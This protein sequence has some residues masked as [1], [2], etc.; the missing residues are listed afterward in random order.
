MLEQK[1]TD[2][3]IDV[4][5]AGAGMAGLIAGCVLAEAG[6]SVLMIEAADRVGGRTHSR[7]L[8]DLDEPIELGAEFV[9]GLPQELLALIDKSGL[10]LEE[11]GGSNYCFDGTKLS[12]C[13]ADSSDG[14]FE[15][16]GAFCDQHPDDD[17]SFAAFLVQMPFDEAAK[18]EA[19]RFVEG[20][21]AADASMISIQALNF[22]QK[23]EDVIEGGR[24]FRIR[25]GY[26]ALADHLFGRFAA[27]GGKLQFETMIT[28]V[29]WSDRQ[30][31]MAGSCRQDDQHLPSARY[32][33]IALPLGVLQS[34]HVDFQP[35][36]DIFDS[37]DTLVMGPV[38]RLTLV[39][40]ERFWDTVSRSYG[41]LSFLF[42]EKTVPGV[43]WTRTP[44][45]QPSFTAWAGGP[46]ATKMSAESFAE[47]S[48]QTLSR[49]FAIA[50][51]KLEDLLVSAH[52]HPW[53]TDDL[54]VGAYSYVRA[55]G[56]AGSRRL[57]SPVENTLFFAG[58]HT[59]VTGHWGTV[60]GAVRSGL[61]AAQQILDADTKAATA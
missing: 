13:P 43:F 40:E 53:N 23:A 37:L 56:L 22:Q 35:C 17:M 7:Y 54:A 47:Q 31:R 29:V 19:L 27:A 61:R 15:K 8:P 55:G 51:N 2:S 9:H 58:E 38:L 25:E 50:K 28:R 46:S 59:D 41:D 4:L 49:A 18:E 12:A 10:H 57:S 6:K 48:L 60:H 32:A 1:G 34:K 33:V 21:N 3:P 16:M 14:I 36:P 24:A 5:I 20:F 44:S 42:A 52:L 26:S 11:V 39:F 30:V 45:R